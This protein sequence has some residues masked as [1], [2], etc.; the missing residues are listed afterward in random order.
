MAIIKK[1]QHEKLTDSNISHVYGLLNRDNPITKKEACSVLNISY[2]TTRLNKIIEEWQERQERTKRIKSEKKGKPPT[3]IEIQQILESYLEGETISNIASSIYRSASFVKQI[4]EKVGIPQRVPE[5]QRNKPYFLP[6]QCISDSFQ[7]DEVAWSAI[8]HAPCIIKKQLD[9]KYNK[10]YDTN[11]YQIY[12]TE[13]VNTEFMYFPQ[14]TQ[15]GFF[16]YSPSYDIGKL[17]HL[18]NYG[19]N[20]KR[21]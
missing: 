4:I 16:A 13:S 8:Y 18:E 20:L 6:E 5:T 10:L 1:K 3:D 14:V 19:V 17:S 7:V 2:N 15:G 21:I 12:V 9:E 11:C